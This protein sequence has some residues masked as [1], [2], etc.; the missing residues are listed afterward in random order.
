MD[1]R[2]KLEIME[3]LTQVFYNKFAG[4]PREALTSKEGRRLI[5]KAARIIHAK[6]GAEEARH[7]INLMTVAEVIP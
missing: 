5:A 4:Y 2:R 7:F 1:T 6:D 3:T